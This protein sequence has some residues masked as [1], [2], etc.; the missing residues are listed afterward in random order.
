MAIEAKI[1][2]K[3]LPCSISCCTSLK[4]HPIPEIL[5]ACER[6]RVAVSSWSSPWVLTR[7]TRSY[8]VPHWITMNGQR[9]KRN[10]TWYRHA[11][12]VAIFM[13]YRPAVPDHTLMHV[14][15]LAIHW[16][17]ALKHADC[18]TVTWTH[19]TRAGYFAFQC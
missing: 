2:D 17:L 1:K 10:L 5:S 7:I 14:S 18:L 16:F 13:Q 4:Y 6:T 9:S 19:S 3:I 11:V 15:G 8:G 12:P